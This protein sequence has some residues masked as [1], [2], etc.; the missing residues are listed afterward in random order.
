MSKQVIAVITYDPEA[1]EWSE[2][3]VDLSPI[4]IGMLAILTDFELKVVAAEVGMRVRKQFE[5]PPSPEARNPV[6]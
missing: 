2:W 6:N 1:E 5:M 3:S 4:G